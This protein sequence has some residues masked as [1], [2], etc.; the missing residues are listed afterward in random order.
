MPGNLLLHHLTE[1]PMD[2]IRTFTVYQTLDGWFWDW[3][4]MK[5]SVGPFQTLPE[6]LADLQHVMGIERHDPTTG[7]CPTCGFQIKQMGP[8]KAMVIE[9]D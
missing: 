5:R 2:I 6:V 9:E 4:H 7:P 8:A 1:V 3:P